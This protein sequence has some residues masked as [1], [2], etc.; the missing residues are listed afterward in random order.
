MKDVEFELRKHHSEI[1]KFWRQFHK[2]LV[3]D[4]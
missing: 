4:K 2:K 1:N 3:E